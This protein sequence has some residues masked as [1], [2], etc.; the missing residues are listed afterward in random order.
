M[1]SKDGMAGAHE[2]N[3]HRIFYYGHKVKSK[4]LVQPTQAWQVQ[5]RSTPESSSERE[6]MGIVYT[7]MHP[8]NG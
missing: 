8:L 4:V 1:H 2:I 3:Q 5:T 6:N 7:Q